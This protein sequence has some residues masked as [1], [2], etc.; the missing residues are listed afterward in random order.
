[1]SQSCNA[2]TSAERFCYCLALLVSLAIALDAWL[3]LGPL[4][5]GSLMAAAVVRRLRGERAGHPVERTT[6]TSN[7]YEN[8]ARSSMEMAVKKD[9]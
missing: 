1:M 7:V 5:Q 9:T 2:A 8:V 3:T 4:V 6:R